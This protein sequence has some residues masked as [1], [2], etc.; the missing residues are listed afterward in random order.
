M[1]GVLRNSISVLNKLNKINF[2]KSIWS[3][4]GFDFTTLFNAITHK[5]P[6][7]TLSQVIYFIFKAKLRKSI[8]HSGNCT[9]GSSTSEQDTGI[10]RAL[11][12]AVLWTNIFHT[13]LHLDMSENLFQLGSL[14]NVWH[15]VSEMIVELLI[16][17]MSFHLD[18]VRLTLK[19]LR[20]EY[21]T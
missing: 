21:R 7:K 2:R 3:I 11:E 10:P 15:Q 19:V 12:Q 9:T 8:H 17:M 1:F 13:F 6:I 18:I 16:M 14:E 4:S 5:F 20:A